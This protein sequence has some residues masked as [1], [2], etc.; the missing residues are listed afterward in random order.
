MGDVPLPERLTGALEEGALRCEK[1]L[2]TDEVE[3]GVE[4][5]AGPKPKPTPVVEKPVNVVVNAAG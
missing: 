4:E 1:G 2:D 3:V 5:R